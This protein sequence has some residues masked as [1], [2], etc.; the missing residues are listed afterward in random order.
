MSSEPAR[1][2]PVRFCVF[3]TI[4]LL[5]WAFGPPVVVLVASAFGLWAYGHAWR[6]GLRETKCFLRDPR[7][8]MAYL[9]TAFVV[10]LV[11]LL[12]GIF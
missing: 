7:I 2:D 12:R 9:A 1:F 3:T 8:A 5:A 10:A 6:H 11:F 4:A